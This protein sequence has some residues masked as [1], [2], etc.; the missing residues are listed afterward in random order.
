VIAILF[1]QF[2]Q[3][4]IDSRRLR[5]AQ[6]Q[7]DDQLATIDFDDKGSLNRLASAD[8]F[9]DLILIAKEEDSELPSDDKD[10]VH[11]LQD[12]GIIEDDELV[13]IPELN[14]GQMDFL[15]QTKNLLQL[16]C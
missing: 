9:K 1:R 13:K 7:G 3:S 12:Q 11:D 2:I 4:A 10:V 15:H 8:L 6:T 14:G 5:F 16:L